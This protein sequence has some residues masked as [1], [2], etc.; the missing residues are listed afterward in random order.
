[1]RGTRLELRPDGLRHNAR[2]ARHKAGTS[3]VY[4]M[5]KADGYGHG[6]A[7][8]ARA[9]EAE[10]DGFGVAVLEE[11]LAL[12]QLGVE[13]PLMLLEGFMNR[14]ELAL[15][16][17]AKLETVVHSDWQVALLERHPPSGPGLPVWLKLNTGMNRL[18]VPREQAASLLARLE[19]I[20]GVH[21][22]GVMSHF[23]CADQ[24]EDGMSDTQLERLRETAGER[25]WSAAN[26][27]AL[28]R[29][30]Q[31]HGDLVRPGI[32]L[33]GSSP[34]E[35]RSA[36]ELELAV[37]QRLSARIIAVNQVAPGDS[38]GY[39]ATWTASEATR[40]GVVSIGYGDGYPR[41]APNG[42]PVAVNGVRTRLLGRVSMDMI[43]VDLTGLDADVGSEVELWGDT[44]SVDEVAQACGTISYELFCQLTT[45]PE[46][47]I[48]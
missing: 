39:G 5:V 42:T 31:S 37:T 4:A 44:V 45:R 12:H 33:Y 22:A 2:V 41:H 26:S 47:V 21:P 11:A 29:Y 35:G 24:A 28:C 25:P 1:M 27:A 48:G 43:T 20:P 30:P 7:L 17:K 40:I 15:A 6:A 23:A 18:G 36:A 13:R 8:V 32:M 9:L 19:A 38:V 46:R 3:R 34:L 14:D 16:A 10:V